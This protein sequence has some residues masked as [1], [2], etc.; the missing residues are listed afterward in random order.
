MWG[1]QCASTEVAAAAASAALRNG[2]V[3]LTS[4]VRSDVIALSPPLVISEEQV[5]HA[6]AVLAMCLK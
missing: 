1:I 3:V 4:G 2:V 5:R 6:I